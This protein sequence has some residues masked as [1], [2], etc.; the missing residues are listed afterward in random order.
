MA[1]LDLGHSLC[2]QCMISV[3]P[4][5]L[6]CCICVSWVHNICLATNNNSVNNIRDD[7]SYR[8]INCIDIFPFNDVD[9]DDDFF[10]LH[11]NVNIDYLLDES[12]LELIKYDYRENYD[13]DNNIDPD[14]S[15][16][17]N[18]DCKYYTEYKF[19]HKINIVQDFSII[20]FNCISLSANLTEIIT[21][22]HGLSQNFD[23]IAFS[24]T[25]FISSDNLNIFSLPGY[26]FCHM[27]RENRRGGGVA[28]Y[29]KNGIKFDVMESISCAVD[30]LLECISINVRVSRNKS[31]I[32]T[33]IYSQPD[34]KIE[35]CIDIIESF[36][37]YKKSD[38]Y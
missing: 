22:L 23:I 11:S 19:I 10:D 13:S 25:W 17:I 1:S 20:H 7:T 6:Q 29:M 9:D 30:N 2:N 12:R 21:C 37:N 33:C 24:G 18:F 5:D 26:Q 27:D 36:F 28:I 15:L 35:A 3:L 38:I 34:S 4:D 8:C 16:N 32:V 31:I 14:N